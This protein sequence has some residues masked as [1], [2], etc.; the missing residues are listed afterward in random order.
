M[1][2]VES[3]A[4]QIQDMLGDLGGFTRV[5]ENAFV[6]RRGSAVVAIRLESDGEEDTVVHIEANVV[7]AAVLDA[8]ILRQL[9]EFNHGSAWG[10]FGVSDDGT[11]TV[12]HCLLGSTLS[13]E[14]LQ[15]V[16]IEVARIADD[17]DDVIIEQAGGKT[18]IERLEELKQKPATTVTPTIEPA[19]AE[20]D[21]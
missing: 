21:A 14:G 16:V 15:H 17:W 3:T 11:I 12:H 2:S 9:L 13:K 7:E 1:S 8:E 19:K 10:S 6:A 18:A 20:E 4:E 5:G